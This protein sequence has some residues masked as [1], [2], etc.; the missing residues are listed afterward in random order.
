MEK[1]IKELERIKAE[2]VELF[3]ESNIEHKAFLIGDCIAV[4][5]DRIFECKMILEHGVI[6][7]DVHGNPRSPNTY[8]DKIAQC[9]Y[10]YSDAQK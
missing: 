4:L 1:T 5:E 10:F 7:R 9:D 2:V 8:P 3:E 6:W